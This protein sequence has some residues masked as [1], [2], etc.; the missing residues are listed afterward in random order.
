MSW[1]ADRPNTRTISGSTMCFPPNI[2]SIVVFP[3]IQN[4]PKIRFNTA[5]LKKSF[6]VPDRNGNKSIDHSIREG[7][8]PTC[9]IGSDEEAAISGAEGEGEVI[10]NGL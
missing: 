2:F 5:K 9:A 7:S 6:K 3:K 4:K 10:D 8:L 1:K